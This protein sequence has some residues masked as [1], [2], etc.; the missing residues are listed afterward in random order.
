M[1]SRTIVEKSHTV[2]LNAHAR[3]PD[4]IDMEIWTF[5]FSHVVIKISNTPHPDL[6][7]R[8][9]FLVVVSPYGGGK[10]DLIDVNLSL[11]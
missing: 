1:Y 7:Y 8:I 10:N 9:T 4:T 5:L 2:L 11:Y 6:D 3:W